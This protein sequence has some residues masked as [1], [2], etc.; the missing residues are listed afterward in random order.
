MDIQDE[1]NIIRKLVTA[2]RKIKKFQ[3]ISRLPEIIFRVSNIQDV[4]LISKG[5]DIIKTM[6]NTNKIKVQWVR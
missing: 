6:T 3:S 1:M 4:E 5:Y 2:I